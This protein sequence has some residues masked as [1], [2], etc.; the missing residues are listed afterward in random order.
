MNKIKIE[1]Y[2]ILLDDVTEIDES[3][4]RFTFPD[5]T[6]IEVS[7]DAFVSGE[8]ALVIRK[9]NSPTCD[10]IYIE[11]DASNMVRVK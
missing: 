1:R 6:R 7:E 11:A 2:E 3:I 10:R 9:V 8:A 4:I 5:G